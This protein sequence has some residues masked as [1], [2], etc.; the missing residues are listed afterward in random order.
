MSKKF[1]GIA[2]F[3]VFCLA[4][5][6]NALTI[7]PARIEITGDP[8]TTLRGEIELFNEQEGTRTFFSSF[9]N[10]EPSGDSGAPRFIGAK[11][12]LAT[13]MQTSSQVSLSSGERIKVPYSIAIPINA[14][15]GGYFA[16]VFFGSQPAKSEGGGEVLIGGKIGALILLRV[17][18]EVSEEAGLLQFESINKKRFFTNIPVA[19]MYR[20]SN[21]GG[22]RIVPQ[23]EVK[24]KN[25]FWITSDTLLANKN[26][27]S[28]LPGSTRK[29]E[30]IWGNELDSDNN[31]KSFFESAHTQWKDFHFGWYTA[32]LNLAWGTTN[33]T[34]NASYYFFIFPW[35]LLLLLLLISIVVGFAG[36]AGL[37][38]Y[39]R[40][41]IAQATLKK[42]N[43]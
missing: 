27:G 42:I 30:V 13:W 40:Y 21:S 8:G 24:I 38:R 18:G 28:V 1:Y 4:T 11:N 7:S 15:A 16:A 36:K 33:Q 37:T 26:D 25:T 29:F 17:S 34:A 14:E 10:F 19:F 35:Q 2:I 5:S 20:I 6:V 3:F 32:K 43:E 23:G 41:I 9:E 22:D 12:S 39:N 31:T